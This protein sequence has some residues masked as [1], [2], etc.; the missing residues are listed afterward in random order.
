[1]AAPRPEQ[2]SLSIR[3][4]EPVVFLRS[5]EAVV[6]GLLT[7]T[8]AKPTKVSGI[9]LALQGKAATRWIQGAGPSRLEITEQYKVHSAS[10]VVFKAGPVSQRSFVVTITGLGVKVKGIGWHLSDDYSRSASLDPR[11][12]SSPRVRRPLSFNGLLPE[13][14]DQSQQSQSQSQSFTDPAPPYTP[15]SGQHSFL[16]VDSYP[17][18]TGQSQHHRSPSVASSSR[19]GGS[20]NSPVPFTS[21][22]I[23]E[24]PYGS[25]PP[26]SLRSIRDLA[27]SR[28]SS[29]EEGPE[30]D[31]ESFDASQSHPPKVAHY[32][33]SR[34]ATGSS[35]RSSEQGRGRSQSRFSFG[36]VAR[37]FDTMRQRVRSQSPGS[38]PRTNESEERGRT[39]LKG[40]ARVSAHEVWDTLPDVGVPEAEGGNGQSGD[41][42]AI[43]PQGTY[44]YPIFFTIPSNS[45]PT[46]KTDHG[47]MIWNIKAEVKRPGAFTSRMTAQREV[48]IVCAPADDGED[49]GINLHYRVQISKRSCPVGG[50]IPIQLTIMPMAK[51]KVHQ[52]S[53]Y[54]DERT[55]YYTQAQA[56]A[57][58]DPIQRATLLMVKDNRSDE[59]HSEPILPLISEDPEAFRKSPLYRFL[60]PDD[61]ESEMA[62]SFLGMGPWTIRHQL[63][64]P[65]S[66]AILHPSNRNKGSNIMVDHSLK[67]ILR[68]ER[69]DTS[70]PQPSG[71][72]RK[73]YDI[74]IHTPIQILSCRC[75]PEQTLLPRYGESLQ[76][77]ESPEDPSTCPCNTRHL[78]KARTRSN[79]DDAQSILLNRVTSRQSTYSNASSRSG[80]FSTHRD[81]PS[82]GLPSD[83]A[84]SRNNLYERLVSGLESE[85]G[86]APPS[87]ESFGALQS[88]QEGVLAV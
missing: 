35:G 14:D 20:Q 32:G 38:Q 57:R 53:V 61:D 79:G 44:T 62:S 33:L 74:T 66:C 75:T 47:S 64:V 71:N 2:N 68:V 86:E 67:I 27:I 25:S 30:D 80:G 45:A 12:F 3:L 69:D 19:F 9:E 26:S 24:D 76:G 23:P 17:S 60:G 58:S 72:Q 31:D 43:F 4:T 37:A 54:L 42:W 41:G 82:D 22:S 46:M 77:D 8:L 56:H 52:I 16:N 85:T 50:K 15:P 59:R 88:T 40:K 84:I 70:S 81:G 1:M 11:H 49:E 18:A 83:S 73:L 28:T 63:R 29:I 48:I 55:E 21:S 65:D 5:S 34:I 87:Y 7:L 51:V 36:K 13:R 39:L 10:A 6:R 78:P